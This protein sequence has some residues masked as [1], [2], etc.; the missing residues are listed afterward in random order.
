MDDAVKERLLDQLRHYRDGIEMLEE[1]PA[2]PAGTA[3]DLFAVF[4]E[5]AAV[6][7]EVRTN[8]GW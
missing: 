5:L 2:D 4:V 6:R 1:P 8:P 3:A 7:N